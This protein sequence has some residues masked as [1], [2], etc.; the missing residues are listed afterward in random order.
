MSK[1]PL[2]RRL[3]FLWL[4]SPLVAAIFLFAREAFIP[5]WLASESLYFSIGS[6]GASVASPEGHKSAY[7]ELD[8]SLELKQG[9]IPVRTLHKGRWTVFSG[10]EIKAASRERVAILHL[11]RSGFF[12]PDTVARSEGWSFI[13][14]EDGSPQRLFDLKAT[15]DEVDVLLNALGKRVLGGRSLIE[16]FETLSPRPLH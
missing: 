12:G 16:G 15:P 4:V 13:F 3:A 6:Q 9:Y 5:N 2:I 1:S 14:S 10:L 11:I 7:T 8:S